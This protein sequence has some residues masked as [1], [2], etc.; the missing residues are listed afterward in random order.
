MGSA[1]KTAFKPKP[2][3]HSIFSARP[4]VGLRDE[5][6]AGFVDP[7]HSHQR[8]QLLYACSG[9]MSVITEHCIYAVPPQRCLWISAGVSHEVA[10]RSDVSVRTLYIEPQLHAD[11]NH[12]CRLL[13][14]S[15]FLQALILEVVDFDTSRPMDTR[16]RLIAELL[17][18][19]IWHMPDAPYKAAMPQDKRLRQA[20]QLVAENPDSHADLDKL[21]ELA[22][23][24]RRAFTRLFRHETGMS[25]GDWRRQM[26][27]AEALS[28]MESGQSI[29]RTAYEVGYSS[30]S[31]FSAAF[32]RVFG[33]SP[34]QYQAHAERG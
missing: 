7:A 30:P 16:E 1:P 5:Y 22:C 10:C 14:V 19:E 28:L 8:I 34:S 33:I 29:T 4:I 6:P 2:S 9:V 3:A 31:A 11:G 18:H 12:R 27:L 26:R 24:S 25:F 21:A 20:C 23:M 17:L 15:P 13:D 32:H